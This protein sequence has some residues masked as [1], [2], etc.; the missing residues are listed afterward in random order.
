MKKLLVPCLFL[1]FAA[2]CSE[3][4]SVEKQVEVTK[5]EDGRTV[6][7]TT[8]SGNDTAGPEKKIGLI[9]LFV[10]KEHIFSDPTKDDTFE[11]TVKGNSLLSGNIRFTITNPQGKL[12]YTDSM[13]T[14]DLEASMVYTL[15][16]PAPT[17][18]QREDF[19]KKRL[20][21]FFDKE[22]FSTPAVAPNDSYNAS[23]GEQTAWEA[24]KND[25]NAVGFNYLVGKENGRR[26]AY[27]KLRK[28]VMLVGNF[29]G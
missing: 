12:I 3:K 2:G 14:A 22:N 16:T 5:T 18:K 11:L 29:G 25:K 6:T 13:S 8:T 26:I 21:E 23:F 10:K 1:A 4:K 15:N 24:I 20:N 28:K 9:E 27:S 17:P 7:K 19:V